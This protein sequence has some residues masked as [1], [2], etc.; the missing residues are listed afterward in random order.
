MKYDNTIKHLQELDDETLIRI[1]KDVRGY[2]GEF[3]DCDLLTIEDFREI[4]YDN[5]WDIAEELIEVG[6]ADY[7]FEDAYGWHGLDAFEVYDHL[8]FWLEDL[9]E[10]VYDQALFYYDND[11]N[12]F[13]YSCYEGMPDWL[14]RDEDFLFALLK[15]LAYN[16]CYIGLLNNADKLRE[17][18]ESY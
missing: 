10:W 5:A 17:V 3:V 8:A 14:D 6:K 13:V 7:Y 11:E 9:A 12:D 15:D 1:F 16:N 18:V 2:A 4:Y